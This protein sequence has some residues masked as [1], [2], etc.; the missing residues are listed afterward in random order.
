MR[1]QEKLIMVTNDDGFY[2]AGIQ[3][4]ARAAESLGKVIVIAPDR[5]MSGAG[6]SL[7]LRQVI[8]VRQVD[9]NTYAVEGSP[10]DCV[11]MA[12]WHMLKRKPDLVLS[13]INNGWNIGED[14]LYSGTVAAAMEGAI[15]YIPAI[16]VSCQDGNKAQYSKAAEIT[17]EMARFVLDYLLPNRTYLSINIPAGRINGTKLT[18]LGTR[19]HKNIVIE[20]KDPRHESYYW[21]ARAE[22]EY[23]PDENSDINALKAHYVSITPLKVDIT[24]YDA[25]AIMAK[26]KFE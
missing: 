13:G 10:C 11:N 7:T 12:I 4:L 15:N 6:H 20:K 23:H 24:D 5:E 16:A 19:K 3:E 17:L 25:L 21:L 26:W 2:S 14:A 8:R 9:A 1:K 22:P 18:A